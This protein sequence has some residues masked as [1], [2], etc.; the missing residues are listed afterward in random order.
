M[1]SFFTFY[2]VGIGFSQKVS[3]IV[4]GHWSQEKLERE[5]SNFSSPDDCHNIMEYSGH[6]KRKNPCS[7]KLE[8]IQDLA[9]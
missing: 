8:G 3:T 7:E 2:S 1:C 4:V 6:P 5:H 9:A